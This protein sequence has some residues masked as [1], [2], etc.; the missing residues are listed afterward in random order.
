[1]SKTTANISIDS[2]TKA[3]AQALFAELGMD[4]STAINVFLRQAIRE[5][6]I[7]FAVT[8]DTPNEVTLAAMREA[9]E[10]RRHPENYKGY[11]D[12]DRMMEELLS[13]L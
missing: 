4:L 12:V 10:M 5:N 7:P 11:R 1:M 9:E 6:A 3:K 8:K 13:D 2:D